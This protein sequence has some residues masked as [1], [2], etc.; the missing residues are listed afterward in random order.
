MEADEDELQLVI[1]SIE[2]VDCLFNYVHMHV[3]PY[4]KAVE[5]ERLIANMKKH[6][7][8]ILLIQAIKYPKK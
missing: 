8:P 4:P 1:Y 6:P 5:I 2:D 7:N 3:E